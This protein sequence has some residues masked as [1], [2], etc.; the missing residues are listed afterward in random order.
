MQVLFFASISICQHILS[1]PIPQLTIGSRSAAVP[2]PQLPVLG[3]QDSMQR[4]LVSGSPC[5]LLHRSSK[6]THRARGAPKLVRAAAAV[7]TVQAEPATQ[8]VTVP[9]NLDQY[10]R[11]GAEE[12]VWLREQVR[13]AAAGRC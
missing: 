4:T 11:E 6:R 12:G 10:R 2:P 9:R 5:S 7:E 1:G 3:Q 13:R 8:R